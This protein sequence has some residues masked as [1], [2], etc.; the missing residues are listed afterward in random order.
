MPLLVAVLRE[1]W[2]TPEFQKLDNAHALVDRMNEDLKD[3]F[4]DGHLSV[5]LAAA[6][7]PAVFD[8]P[9][10][11]DPKLVADSSGKSSQRTL[12]SGVF[13][14]FPNH[15]L[16]SNT[17]GASQRV[18]SPWTSTP[19]W[20]WCSMIFPP[21]RRSISTRAQNHVSILSGSVS[22][23]HTRCGGCGMWRSKITS[24]PFGPFRATPLGV[25]ILCPS[26]QDHD[27]A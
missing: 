16:C 19:T 12:F 2:K 22:A 24:K 7:P 3:L 8:D 11:P 17:L 27:G 9:D 26:A 4:H 6:F 18:T 10:K 15:Q 5:R 21:R 20:S 1:R 13:S 23:D 14:A 25:L